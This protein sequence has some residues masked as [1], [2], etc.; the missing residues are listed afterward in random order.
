MTVGRRSMLRSGL[1][2]VA[3][4]SL[5]PRAAEAGAAPAPVPGGP[6]DWPGVRALFQLAPGLAHMSNFFFVS[7][8]APV[9]EAIE[10][11][12]RA[13][14]G[15]PFRTVE[16]CMFG[17]PEH[18]LH[19]AVRR[20]A[21]AYLGGAPDELALTQST[22]M[23]L[24]MIY[25]GLPLQAGDELL[26]TEHDHVAHHEAARMGAARAGA[27]VR[28]IPLFDRFEDLPAISA[29]A[30]AARLRAAIRPATRVVGMT[31]VHSQSG[32][33]L[34][35]RALAQVVREA[36]AGRDEAHRALLVIDGVHGL[37]AE[38]EAVAQTGVD[39]FVSGT[40]KW[41]FGPRGTGLVW[42]RASTWARMRPIFPTFSSE[43]L[44]VAWLQ[45]KP[46]A[47]PPKAD[48]FTPGGFHAYEHEWAVADAFAFHQ[49][50]GRKR[51]ADRIHELNG[52]LKEGL[53][54]IKGVTLYT[55]RSP[56]LSAGLVGFDVAGL[57]AEAAVKRLEAERVIAS[58]S[59]Y[60]RQV[61]RLSAGIMTT[62]GE[63]EASLAAVR[64]LAGAP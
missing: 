38:D 10:R 1:A 54:K 61:V 47:G 36:N 9:R 13:L 12:R 33:K 56:A 17:A 60:R 62:P 41:I 63:I 46:P 48:W 11:H 22:T 4:A 5:R 7:H 59:P 51:I 8:P 58:A 3:A 44:Y 25:L 6:L 21:A 42:A 45:G 26:L 18:N 52:A 53:A 34:P 28:K 15:D 55:P 20:A 49:Q 64:K 19:E 2:A 16:R 35:L 40:H 29:E 37:G 14:D 57:E 50:L 24:A 43:E 32:L 39:V 31:W 23:G 30:I 27:T